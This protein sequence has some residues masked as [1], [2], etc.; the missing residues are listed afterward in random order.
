MRKKKIIK[1]HQQIDDPYFPSPLIRQL[2]TKIML[3][4]EKSKARKILYQVLDYLKEATEQ[5]PLVT[6]EE[7]INELKPQL[8]TKKRRLGG[9]SQLIPKEVSPERGIC[10]ALRWLVA[11]ARKNIKK[12][13]RKG[14]GRPMYYCLAQEIIKAKQK[15]GEAFK[16]KET[17]QQKAK[18]SIAFASFSIYH[19]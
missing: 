12:K 5:D 18:D 1:K 8:E 11:A 3:R 9:T 16:K 13:S 15:T 4:G 14:M 17:E 6:I 2:I 19:S 10:L 7:A